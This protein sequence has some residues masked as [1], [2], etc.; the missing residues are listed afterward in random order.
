MQAG[1]IALVFAW[2]VRLRLPALPISAYTGEPVYA[3]EVKRCVSA[4]RAR[5]NQ[6]GLNMAWW[7][8]LAEKL[9]SPFYQVVIVGDPQAAGTREPRP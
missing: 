4:Q 7:F 3:D 8:D 9:T 1:E 2:I 5:M 6:L